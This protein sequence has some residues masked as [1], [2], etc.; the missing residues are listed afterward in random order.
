MLRS[1][2]FKGF[3]PASETS[4]RV[5]QANR[6]VDTKAERLLRRAVWTLGL[7][8][9]KN[10][11]TLPG[12]PD[13]VFRGAR[14]AVFCDGDFWHGRDW[15]HLRSRL[16]R[17][18]NPQYWIPKIEANRRRDALHRRA[19]RRAGWTVLSLWETDILRHPEAAA[20]KIATA[21]VVLRS[22]RHALQRGRKSSAL[23][24]LDETHRPTPS[25]VRSKTH[26]RHPRRHVRRH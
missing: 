18:A 11:R 24:V 9:R 1:P 5:K 15:G 16:E 25:K 22:V 7:R 14:V 4:S 12:K 13:L 21:L 23:A 10:V 8:Y 3:K 2:S 19:L 6:A 20:G 17:R 26:L